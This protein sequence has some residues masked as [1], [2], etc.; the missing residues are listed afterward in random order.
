MRNTYFLCIDSIENC[1]L[2]QNLSDKTL[3]MTNCAMHNIKKKKIWLIVG[4]RE[5]NL[6]DDKQNSSSSSLVYD[7]WLWYGFIQNYLYY[8]S[9]K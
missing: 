1:L 3:N 9:E 8:F 5:L 2:F 7:L 4:M 6:N